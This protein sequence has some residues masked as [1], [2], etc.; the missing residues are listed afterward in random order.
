M[1]CLNLDGYPGKS[2]KIESEASIINSSGFNKIPVLFIGPIAPEGEVPKGGYEAANRRTINNLKKNN[3]IYMIEL[4]YPKV[5][6]RKLLKI[7]NYLTGFIILIYKF[8]KIQFKFM[9]V[10]WPRPVCH[11]TGLYKQFIYIEFILVTIS[12]LL[13]C[14]VIYEIRAGSMYYHYY[15]RTFIYKYFFKFVIKLSEYIGI[16]GHN[17]NNFINNF[18][19]HTPIYLPNYVDKV[20]SLNSLEDRKRLLENNINLIYFG[21]LDP[22]K[23]L[24]III[25]TFFWLIKKKN[26]FTLEII[27]NPI[28]VNYFSRLK[29]QIKTSNKIT[30][31][32]G[33]PQE[34]L[35]ERLE[36]KHFF[37]FP[38][39]HFGEGHSNSLN[40]AM[41]NGCVPICSDVG[42]NKSVVGQCGIILPLN[43][44][45]EQYS[46]AIW[47]IIS[48][49]K[50]HY[51]SVNCVS[52]IKKNFHRSVIIE[53]YFALYKICSGYGKA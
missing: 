29:L 18:S 10:N 24:N 51:L 25:E 50:W 43:S 22:E 23:G 42:F 47:E 52:R 37:I 1:K 15:N 39:K 14:K 13:K 11:I 21:R 41:A 8:L 16:E 3:K 19:K 2:N 38:T 9:N 7:T 31:S 36:E 35:F 49:K 30:I 33:L 6:N 53:K 17:Y 44:K 40:E 5:R 12:K 28:S 4:P 32:K 20:V 34:E 27:G 46:N 48:N 26:I 45:S